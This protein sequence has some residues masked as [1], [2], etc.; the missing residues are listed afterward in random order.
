VNLDEAERNLENAIADYEKAANDFGKVLVCWVLA[1][2]FIDDEGQPYLAAYAARGM[3][4]WR[5][6]GLIDAAPHAIIYMEEVDDE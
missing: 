2:E 1:A 4:F 5:I 3:P 6:D